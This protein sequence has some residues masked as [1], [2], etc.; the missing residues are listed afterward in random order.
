M[1]GKHQKYLP[2]RA[3][4]IYGGKS[5]DGC[6]ASFCVAM[7]GTFSHDLLGNFIGDTNDSVSGTGLSVIVALA[8]DVSLFSL[9]FIILFYVDGYGLTNSWISQS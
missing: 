1:A 7:Q 8:S 5:G 4:R 9:F 3:E 2:E 6:S